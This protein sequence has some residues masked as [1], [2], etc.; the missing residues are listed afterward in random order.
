MPPLDCASAVLWS[1]LSF[2]IY[3]VFF[4]GRNTRKLLELSRGGTRAVVDSLQQRKNY[5]QRKVCF[6]EEV[7]PPYVEHLECCLVN[8]NSGEG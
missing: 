7:Y 6:I 5:V 2:L 4:L 1:R 3:T 8:E